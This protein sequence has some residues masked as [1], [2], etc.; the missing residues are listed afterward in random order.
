V[1]SILTFNYCVKYFLESS[2]ESVS[3]CLDEFAKQT[4]DEEAVNASTFQGIIYS[5]YDISCM[6]IS[7]WQTV[8][9]RQNNKGIFNIA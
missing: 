6:G 9:L 8:H 5:V 4:V 1:Y 3:N 2:Y 7:L